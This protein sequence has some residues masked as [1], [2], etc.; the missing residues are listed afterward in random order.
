MS[1]AILFLSIELI[2]GLI[3]F[4][5]VL[6][7]AILLQIFLSKKPNKWFGYILPICF[8][9]ISMVFLIPISINTVWFHNGFIPSVVFFDIVAGV[10]INIPTAVLLAIYFHYRR[11]LQKEAEIKKMNIQD[12]D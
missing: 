9:L 1:N 4:G 12:L 8:F 11:K 3:V 6:T 10:L 7:G 2:I 5:L